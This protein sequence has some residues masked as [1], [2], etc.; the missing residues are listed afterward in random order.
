MTPKKQQAWMLGQSLIG[1]NCVET[2]LKKGHGCFSWGLQTSENAFVSTLCWDSGCLPGKDG[3]TGS[4]QGPRLLDSATK[5]TA[6]LWTPWGQDTKPGEAS[7][8][9]KRRAGE[10]RAWP[11]KGR[12][13]KFSAHPKHRRQTLSLRILKTKSLGRS[14]DKPWQMQSWS[15]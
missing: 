4:W 5:Y 2:C 7:V 1:K 11:H 13:G 3:E 14:L 12:V 8:Q 15:G 6:L 10:S 9:T